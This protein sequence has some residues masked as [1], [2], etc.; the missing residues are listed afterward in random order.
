MGAHMAA[1]TPKREVIES[2][3][4]YPGV[5][6]WVRG[7]L[8]GRCVHLQRDRVGVEVEYARVVGALVQRVALA[9][10]QAALGVLAVVAHR[11]DLVLVVHADGL[12][13]DAIAGEVVF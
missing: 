7:W 1:P 8:E 5:G 4:L 13:V 9:P 11:G 10:A 3:A 2:I 6:S 12:G